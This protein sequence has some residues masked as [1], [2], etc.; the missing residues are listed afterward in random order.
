MIMRL[1]ILSAT[2]LVEGQTDDRFQNTL[3][4][5]QLFLQRM[6]NNFILERLQRHNLLG[7]RSCIAD[8]CN[9]GL[10]SHCVGFMDARVHLVQAFDGCWA[11][12]GS[13]VI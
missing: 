8:L 4:D 12:E 13:A 6:P 3:G 10:S 1:P 11:L 5:S 2:S 7:R 9:P